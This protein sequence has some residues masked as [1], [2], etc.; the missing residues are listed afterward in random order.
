MEKF[1]I[2]VNQKAVARATCRRDRQ[3]GIRLNEYEYKALKM[4]SAEIGLSMSSFA[5]EVLKA[6]G[7]FR[8]DEPKK[9]K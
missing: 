8:L 7:A 5:H 4:R 2:T 1:Y 3:V 9:S 6:A